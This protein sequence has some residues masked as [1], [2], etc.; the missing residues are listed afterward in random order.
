MLSTACKQD[1][2]VLG[3]PS[4]KNSLLLKGNIYQQLDVTAMFGTTYC[5]R[6]LPGIRNWV[7]QSIENLRI[8]LQDFRNLK[9]AMSQV[10]YTSHTCL[11]SFLKLTN[12]A[13]V[14]PL[15]PG[16]QQLWEITCPRI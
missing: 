6:T 4:F 1:V 2:V 14:E 3:L 9:R 5:F 7:G 11:I 8:T 15:Q 13:T 16:S 10:G 12:S